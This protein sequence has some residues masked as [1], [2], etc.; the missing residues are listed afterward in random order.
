MHE[1]RADAAPKG[2]DA[3]RKRLRDL[4]FKFHPDRNHGEKLNPHDVTVALN[5]VIASL[6]GK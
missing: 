1:V 6:G 4:V 5:E 3:I 2:N